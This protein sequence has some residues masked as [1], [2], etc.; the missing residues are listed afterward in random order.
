MNDHFGMSEKKC[1]RHGV[2]VQNCVSTLALIVFVWHLDHKGSTRST[3]ILRPTDVAGGRQPPVMHRLSMRLSSG[4]VA[5]NV[6]IASSGVNSLTDAWICRVTL[7][8]KYIL[9]R[10][11]SSPDSVKITLPHFMV[12]MLCTHELQLFLDSIV[13]QL[14]PVGPN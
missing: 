1:V 9:L 13:H 5:A 6:S 8:C 7:V 4:R 10:W 14:R 11:V 3:V 12:D 2:C